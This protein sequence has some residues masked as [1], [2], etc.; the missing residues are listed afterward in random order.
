MTFFGGLMQ[1][2]GALPWDLAMRV[3]VAAL[4]GAVIGVEREYR[5]HD[6]GL[7]TNILVSLGS[8]LFTLLSIFGF[9]ETGPAPDVGRDPARI[10]AQIVSGIG[11]LGA[12]AVFRDGDRVRGMTTAATI[13]LVAAVGMAAGAGS[14]FIAVVTT[15]VT[16]IVLSALLPLSNKLEARGVQ[17]DD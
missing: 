10:A 14:Y 11:F 5:G 1:Q 6:A 7:R 13:W 15:I 4:L 17:E 9:P 8:C 16:L 3:L 12:G 2:F